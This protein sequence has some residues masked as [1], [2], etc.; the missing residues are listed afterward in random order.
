MR[1]IVGT[2]DS[3][4]CC[5]QSFGLSAPCDYSDGKGGIDPNKLFACEYKRLEEA[6]KLARFRKVF[7]GILYDDK[8]KDECKTKGVSYY[9]PNDCPP[10]YAPVVLESASPSYY[11]YV[12]CD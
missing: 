7:Q 11:R 12:K 4:E 3:N 8:C 5:N 6:E 9:A 2:G 1:N 10:G